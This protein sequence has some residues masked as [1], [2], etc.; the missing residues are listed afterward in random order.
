[1][2]A[3]PAPTITTR[4]KER[5]MAVPQV[6]GGSGVVPLPTWGAAPGCD[7]R[8]HFSWPVPG[9]LYKRAEV[10]TGAERGAGRPR[11]FLAAARGPGPGGCTSA[12]AAA[13]AGHGA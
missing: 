1:M 2:P 8:A 3:G 5:F 7:R 6:R 11:A 13:P 4:E 12:A 10:S 9:S